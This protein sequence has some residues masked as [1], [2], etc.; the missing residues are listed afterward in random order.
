MLS[1]SLN[2]SKYRPNTLILITMVHSIIKLYPIYLL[3]L[4]RWAFSSFHYC[5]AERGR[6]AV[7]WFVLWLV[8]VLIPPFAISTEHSGSGWY[9]SLLL[10]MERLVCTAIG[11]VDDV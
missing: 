5:I 9:R 11:N 3:I 6:S 1:T 10:W 2:I 7:S 4:Y 8:Q